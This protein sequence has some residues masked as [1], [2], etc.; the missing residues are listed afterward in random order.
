MKGFKNGKYQLK[1]K[2]IQM[3]DSIDHQ[4]QHD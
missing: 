1:I 3:H 4:M 2:I